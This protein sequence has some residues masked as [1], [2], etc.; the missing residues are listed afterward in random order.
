[1]A[2]DWLCL[3]LINA[4]AMPLNIAAL[5]IRP[6]LEVVQILPSRR[7]GSYL[8]LEARQTRC[9]PLRASLPEGWTRGVDRLRV[10]A[11]TE[12]FD[13]S[14]LEMPPLAVSY[15]SAS[16]RSTVGE[17]VEAQ[18][19]GLALDGVRSAAGLLGETHLWSS[20]R[21]SSAILADVLNIF[22]GSGSWTGDAIE[23]SGPEN[24]PPRRG[25]W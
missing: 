6:T 15:S 24:A 21:R 20:D 4:S 7:M 12:P 1:M 11:S 18:W 9:V 5:D 23:V 22:A 14:L 17:V 13:L 16:V 8:L 3:E 19:A 2:G 25:A 10:V